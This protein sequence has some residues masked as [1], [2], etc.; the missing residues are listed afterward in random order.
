VAST[1]VLQALYCAFFFLILSLSIITSD[2]KSVLW[3]KGRLERVLKELDLKWSR[4]MVD[5]G[6]SLLLKSLGRF[7][8]FHC[9]FLPLES[10]GV[11]HSDTGVS[12]CN[13]GSWIC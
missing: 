10:L 1:L 6:L 13:L 7:C 12:M 8:Y 11:K 4:L 5:T 2:L 3:C 9:L